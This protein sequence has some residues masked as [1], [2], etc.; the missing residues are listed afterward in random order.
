MTKIEY[1][2]AMSDAQ[3]DADVMLG[4][5]GEY[6]VAMRNAGIEVGGEVRL[7]GF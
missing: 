4:A 1:E 3:G 6:V 7:P 2:N 5:C